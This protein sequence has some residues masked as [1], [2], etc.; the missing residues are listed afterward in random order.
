MRIVENK[1]L[2]QSAR[3]LHINVKEGD[4]QG[5]SM[6]F[7]HFSKRQELGH[8]KLETYVPKTGPRRQILKYEDGPRTVKG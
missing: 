5:K 3:I 8:E 6:S 1:Q 4:K 7:F 2:R